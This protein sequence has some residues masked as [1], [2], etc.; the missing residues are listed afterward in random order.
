MG[1]L[2]F[3]SFTHSCWCACVFVEIKLKLDC[4][5]LITGAS[6]CLSIFPVKWHWLW[7]AQMY[8]N[9]SKMGLVGISLKEGL[10]GEEWP[11]CAEGTVREVIEMLAEVCSTLRITAGTESLSTPSVG[12]RGGQKMLSRSLKGEDFS[13][14]YHVLEKRKRVEGC[15]TAEGS[16]DQM[17]GLASRWCFTQ[18]QLWQ[19]HAV[20]L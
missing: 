9:S 18:M 3:I 2:Q 10:E 15:D 8:C 14:L 17:E 4:R 11:G 12:V 19:D 16:A 5:S 13:F 7:W 20:I 1:F 6:L